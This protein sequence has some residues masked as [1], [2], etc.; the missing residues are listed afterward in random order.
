MAATKTLSESRSTIR[1][2]AD[3]ETASASTAFVTDDEIDD[4]F[5]EHLRILRDTLLI[6]QGDSYFAKS[7]TT[8]TV[9][10]QAAYSFEEDF[11]V[12]NLY[13]LLW[14]QVDNG[15]LYVDMPTWEYSEL[16]ELRTVE[17]NGSPSLYDYRYRLLD[18]GIEVRPYPTVTTHTITIH[19][20]PLFTPLKSDG[21]QVGVVM[22]PWVRYAELGAAID[23]MAKEE[24]DPTI[25]V[26]QRSDIAVRINKLAGT[27]DMGRPAKVQDTRKDNASDV[28]FNN[29]RQY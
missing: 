1:Q 6:A 20:V 15:T 28:W 10:N 2:L 9:A 25:L 14:V 4:R 26:A 29:D 24:A 12:D 7:T 22:H 21:D 11:G 3:M 23:L 16:S 19:Y 13:R 17:A 8:A 5:N 27:R 18:T